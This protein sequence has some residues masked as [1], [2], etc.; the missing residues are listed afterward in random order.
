MNILI[1]II[2]V[3]LISVILWGWSTVLRRIPLND[4]GMENV[5]RVLKLESDE[6][7]T[8]VLQ[9]GWMT[10]KEWNKLQKKHQATLDQKAN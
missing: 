3:I 6:Y 9:R 1:P 8:Q 5:E 4:Y 7:R 10:N 2:I